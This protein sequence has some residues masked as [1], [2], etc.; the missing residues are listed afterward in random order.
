MVLIQCGLIH[1]GWTPH[2]EHLLAVCC[3]EATC[4]QSSKVEKVYIRYMCTNRYILIGHDR[5]R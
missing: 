2:R 4:A 1:S 5:E 3:R